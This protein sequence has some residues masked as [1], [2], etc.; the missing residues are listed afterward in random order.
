[1]KLSSTC[2]DYTSLNL[3]P[4]WM[5]GGG[6]PEGWLDIHWGLWE[7]YWKPLRKQDI[8]DR[9]EQEKRLKNEEKRREKN[10]T[11]QG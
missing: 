3:G 10:E 9:R 2:L 11:L 5:H 6:S 8:S 1:M 7:P 4:N